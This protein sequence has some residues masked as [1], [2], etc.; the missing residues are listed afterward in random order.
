MIDQDRPLASKEV[1]E[2]TGL[3][4]SST[5]TVLTYMIAMKKVDRVKIGGRYKYFLKEIDENR[6]EGPSWEIELA[7]VLPDGTERYEARYLPRRR[8]A[9]EAES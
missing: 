4:K 2:L 3:S 7:E 5:Y 9:K 8:A 6:I 1:E